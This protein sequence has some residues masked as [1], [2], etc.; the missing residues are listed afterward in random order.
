M[1]NTTNLSFR[2]RPTLAPLADD[3]AGRAA[4][5]RRR[6]AAARARAA[7]ASAEAADLEAAAL[8]ADRGAP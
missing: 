5:L 3:N 4:D 7:L 8:L 2:T 6:A 1:L